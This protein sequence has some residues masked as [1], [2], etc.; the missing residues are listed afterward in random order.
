MTVQNI[1]TQTIYT[2]NGATVSFATDFVFYDAQ[3]LEVTVSGALQTNYT[4][5]GG[6]GGTGSVV[7][8]AAPA[9][10]ATIT[11]QRKVP[12]TQL[13]DYTQITDFPAASHEKALDLAAMRDQQLQADLDRALKFP[14][15]D[16]TSGDIA[17]AVSRANKLLGFGAGGQLTYTSPSTL[18]SG[19]TGNVQTAVIV[20]DRSD[21]AIPVSDL[22]VRKYNPQN[23]AG[24]VGNGITSDQTAIDAMVADILNDLPGRQNIHIELPLG[25][26]LVGQ[27][28]IIN[29]VTDGIVW[30]DVSIDGN[31]CLWRGNT[32]PGTPGFLNGDGVCHL[33]GFRKV[34]LTRINGDGLC[35]RSFASLTRSSGIATAVFTENH[36]YAEGECFAIGGVLPP[37]SA[38]GDAVQRSWDDTYNGLHFATVV[39]PTTV[40]FPIDP[41]T[42]A[43]PNISNAWATL[44]HNPKNTPGGDFLR[45][46][47]SQGVI[48]TDSIIRHVN[49][50]AFYFVST[51]VSGNFTGKPDNFGLPSRD[52]IIS[53]V[54]LENVWQ[55]STTPSGS[56]NINISNVLG[57]HLRGGSI[58]F[59]SQATNSSVKMSNIIAADFT[60]AGPGTTPNGIIIEGTLSAHVSDCLLNRAGGIIILPN[61]GSNR[62]GNRNNREVHV[63]GCLIVDGGY[64]FD[65][66]YGKGTT[67]TKEQHGINI[68]DSAATVGEDSVSKY[69]I[70][71]NTVIRQRGRGIALGVNNAGNYEDMNVSNNTIIHPALTGIYARHRTSSRLLLQNNFFRK[72]A[73]LPHM[74]PDWTS[75]TVYNFLDVV[76]EPNS[77]THFRKS[78]VGAQTST[79]RPSPTSGAIGADG[80]QWKN[81]GGDYAILMGAP[82]A[83]AE[84]FTSDAVVSNNTITEWN[85]GIDFTKTAFSAITGNNIRKVSGFAIN[86]GNCVEPLVDG[87]IIKGQSTMSNPINS[88][89]NIRP[90]Y[91]NNTLDFG[92]GNR[93]CLNLNNDENPSV[94][95]NI[96]LNTTTT[97]SALG[98]TLNNIRGAR[99]EGNRAVGCTVGETIFM[100][101]AA[102]RRNLVGSFVSYDHN[103]GLSNGDA[104]MLTTGAKIGNR[105]PSPGESGEVYVTQGGF[106]TR[107]SMQNNLSATGLGEIVLFSETVFTSGAFTGVTGEFNW[108]GRQ[109]TYAIV[110]ANGTSGAA[111]VP[112]DYFGIPDG[113]TINSC[114]H[115]QWISWNDFGYP[116][117]QNG[118]SVNYETGLDADNNLY[119]R[120]SGAVIS[121]MSY[122]SGTG[123]V[124]C[125][126]TAHGITNGDF[127][128]IARAYPDAFQIS[129]DSDSNGVR[130]RNPITVIDANTFSYMAATGLP[131]PAMGIVLV[132]P[133]TNVYQ[134][135][136][137]VTA[138]GNLLTI[139][140]TAHGLTTGN[141]I[142]LRRATVKEY[143]VTGLAC[144]VLNANTL[145]VVAPTA[146]ASSPA[147]AEPR[148]AVFGMYWSE[149]PNARTVGAGGF[150][151]P[152]G[153]GIPWGDLEVEFFGPRAVV[154]RRNVTPLTQTVTINPGAVGAGVTVTSAT[155]T[156]TGLNG[157][158]TALAPT[159]LTTA[160]AGFDISATITGANSYVLRFTNVTGGTL[161]PGDLQCFV[162]F[163]NTLPWSG[164]EGVI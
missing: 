154:Q 127:H 7:F 142:S 162:Q 115:W 21:T 42:S 138:S 56:K 131:A 147:V 135:N 77:R 44:Q 66:L 26:Y 13:L 18:G 139:T 64:A 161:T 14:V 53:N 65:G 118:E 112:A 45:I 103:T 119:A 145:T 50:H 104:V 143:N 11:L 43:E 67:L 149:A 41:L 148:L 30:N 132:K 83:S 36:N 160:G 63:T 37:A 133:G 146:P 92:G 128:T 89:N 126:A 102:R 82:E 95:N 107:N 59:A 70:T 74:P 60:S 117:I 85:N 130:D 155:Q 48:L 91:L 140:A 6:L 9:A 101:V 99:V 19:G 46:V 55:T 2:G 68:G 5:V 12:L 39:N 113:A 105:N 73:S 114:G 29:N 156:L 97:L 106:N 75:G 20:A 100:N 1:D 61:P 69:T 152:K 80:V 71:H 163:V 79:T 121:A 109:P 84:E 3:H 90:Q 125:T 94:I 31:W 110:D 144:T 93:K 76:Y 116:L 54:L 137:S 16:T 136:V 129:A 159:S 72:N 111:A 40:T 153:R 78:N 38:R 98:T 150:T 8:A 62:P 57:K 124:T 86:V 122:N 96:F 22:I 49:D 157:K 32:K 151:T 88:G 52:I 4:V 28:K 27:L 23:Y 15:G 108:T 120:A 164:T 34:H 123:V 24:F 58:K 87:N 158:M 134:G 33:A 51:T 81:L 141:T 25:K 10:G 17:S 47:D 35:R